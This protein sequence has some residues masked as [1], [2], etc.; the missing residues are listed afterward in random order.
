MLIEDSCEIWGEGVGG[1][2]NG[3]AL[4]MD[5]HINDYLSLNFCFMFL[6]ITIK[7]C[8]PFMVVIQVNHQ[9]HQAVVGDFLP[10]Q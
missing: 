10:H 2:A 6:A 8:L 9:D 3:F 7:V 5:E 4:I 1:H